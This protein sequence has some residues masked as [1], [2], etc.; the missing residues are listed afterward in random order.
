M[1]EKP[2]TATENMHKFVYLANEY[3]GSK[4]EQLYKMFNFPLLDYQA[5]AYLAEDLGFV[6]I[7]KKKSEDH[8]FEVVSMP[9]D[10]DF[11]TDVR[12]LISTLQFVFLRLSKD[13]IDLSEWELNAWME[14]YPTH[15]QFIAVKWL[16]NNGVLGTYEIKVSNRE[17]KLPDTVQTYYTTAGNESKRWGEK[18]IPDKKRI[19]RDK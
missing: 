4:V 12:N 18:Q 11:G 7:V 5:A 1:S 2:S 14:G 8:R 3:K 6:K 10:L 15:D 19:I 13:E 9:E 17:V 16:L